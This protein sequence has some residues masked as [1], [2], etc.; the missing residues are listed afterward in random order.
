MAT[1]LCATTTANTN[2][3]RPHR[4]PGADD[5]RSAPPPSSGEEH[6]ATPTIDFRH[7]TAERLRAHRQSGAWIRMTDG[8]K[9]AYPLGGPPAWSS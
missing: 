2:P 1:S 9:V 6:R 7:A 4:Q 3:S 8:R 5:K